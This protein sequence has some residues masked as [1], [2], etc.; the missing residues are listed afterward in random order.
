MSIPPLVC[1]TPPPP[2]QCEDDK[3]PEEFDL[4]YNLSQEEDENNDYE[5]GNFST[6]NIHTSDNGKKPNILSPE[7]KV[8]PCSNLNSGNENDGRESLNHIPDLPFEDDIHVED[9]NL[10][11]NQET[12][13]SNTKCNEEVCETDSDDK[14][15]KD[16][17]EDIPFVCNVKQNDKLSESNEGKETE[18]ILVSKADKFESPN[19]EVTESLSDKIEIINNEEDHLSSSN[20][21]DDASSQDLMDAKKENPTEE[22]HTDDDFD[23]FDEFNFIQSDEKSEIV[24]DSND[25]WANST[26]EN[27][28]FGGFAANFENANS[29]LSQPFQ[30][31]GES[32][33]IHKE[34]PSLNT[35]NDDD[36]DFGDFD[37][38]KSS[39]TA[40]TDSE[41]SVEIVQNPRVPILNFQSISEN[42]I[43]ES[44]NKVLETVFPEEI[45]NSGD[46]LE[47]KLDISLGETW[48]YL[49]E[50]DTRQPY[51]V[52]WNNSL[53]QKT[54]LR[55]LCID[56]RNILFGPKWSFNTPKYAVNLSAAPL[57]PQKPTTQLITQQREQSSDSEKTNN[58]SAWVDPFASDGQES[59]N[60]ENESTIPEP[61]PTDLDVFESTMSTKTDKIFSSTMNIQPIRQI[62]LPDTHIFTPTDSE[63]PRSKTIHYNSNPTPNILIPQPIASAMK[64]QK[65]QIMPQPA[66]IEPQSNDEYWDFQ[67]FRSNPD[68]KS[69]DLSKNLETENKDTLVNSNYTVKTQVLQPIKSELIMPTLNWPDPGEVKETFDDFSDFVSNSVPIDDKQMSSSEIHDE[70]GKIKKE[71]NNFTDTSLKTNGNIEDDFDMFQSVLPTNVMKVN[72][73][74]ILSNQEPSI[75]KTDF[76]A[77]IP[78][79]EQKSD[80]IS[81]LSMRPTENNIQTVGNFSNA[82]QPNE[83]NFKTQ[84]S[85]IQAPSCNILLPITVT[86]TTTHATQQNTGQ[87]LQPLSLESYSQINWPNPGIDLQDLSRFNPVESL[88]SFKSDVSN[89]SKNSSPIH[90]HK[91]VTNN[92]VSDDDIWGDFVSI[93]P[94]SQQSLP[95]K[96]SVFADDDEWTDFVSSPSVNTQNGLNTIS[97]NVDTNS[98]IQKSS[99]STKYPLKN[100]DIPLDIPTLNYI[101]PKT[102][103]QKSFNERHF[104]NL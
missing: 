64:M 79:L 21:N 62:S 33:I 58:R 28:D 37:D 43:I 60:V 1:S 72:S 61:G 51:M 86:S 16:F 68:I 4:H 85:G 26:T 22:N 34:S 104:Q 2:E 15:D 41:E 89:H 30:V 24:I 82:K 93:K 94:K 92:Q 96:Q 74:N 83:L 20:K 66:D 11:I 47:N 87:I 42:Q 48:S 54:L 71:N 32:S 97:L 65:D 78:K 23:N 103:N 95:K 49:K 38:F 59:C 57:Q 40:N 84:P 102:A 19:K 88:Q 45:S 18:S 52:N 69:P 90:N 14:I 77:E 99:N 73:E 17:Q 76:K 67:E 56:S 9:L 53:A 91:N 31:E 50:T 98:S 39:A 101:T 100:N 3:D 5:F 12:M 8:E 13:N 80:N 25:P 7:N 27:V 70:T 6:F 10:V 81:T 63:T 55:A 29:A 35:N 46:K 44:I 36:D 75:L